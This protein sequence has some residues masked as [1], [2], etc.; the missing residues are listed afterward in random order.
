MNNKDKKIIYLYVIFGTILFIILFSINL[1]FNKYIFNLTIGNTYQV[2]A[3]QTNN[4]KTNSYQKI[5]KYIFNNKIKTHY[6]F[7][8]VFNKRDNLSFIRQSE[9]SVIEFKVVL[10]DYVDERKF[11][12]ILN[13]TYVGQLEEDLNL[14][15]QNSNLFDYKEILVSYEE[16]RK[17]EIKK[18]HDRLVNSEF[19]QKYPLPNCSGSPEQC[20]KN[21]TQYYIFIFDNLISNSKELKKFF[22]IEDSDKSFVTIVNDFLLNRD[23]YNSKFIKNI[24]SDDVE[25]NSSSKF[26][27][28]FFDKKFKDAEKSKLFISF[29]F[30]DKCLNLPQR[31][32]SNMSKDFNKLTNDIKFEIANPYELEYLKPEEEKTF[33]LI[34]EIVKILGFTILLVYILFILTNKFLRRKLK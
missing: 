18:A 13:E 17:L 9:E 1:F 30:K 25:I 23:L 31:C 3:I 21:Y 12:K 22:N 33:N 24:L 26:K 11:K 2:S 5:F 14:L 28:S 20:L 34:T 6:R 8:N 10:N 15:E 16:A 4:Y 7:Y 27:N 29:S 32:L 19:S